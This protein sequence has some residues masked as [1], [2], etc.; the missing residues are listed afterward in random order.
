[1]LRWMHYQ[2]KHDI[3]F[4][5]EEI[6][7]TRIHKL[8]SR[9]RHGHN[10]KCDHNV[11]ENDILHSFHLLFLLSYYITYLVDVCFLKCMLMQFFFVVYEL[12]V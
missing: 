1:V 2:C 10:R 7:E 3:I 5:K 9:S 11:I 8:T 4:I 6:T 12:R